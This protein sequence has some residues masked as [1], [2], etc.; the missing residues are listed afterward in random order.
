MTTTPI[1]PAMQNAIDAIDGDVVA[2]GTAVRYYDDAMQLHY[3]AP[4]SDIPR[5]VVLLAQDETTGYSL[6][7]AET[8]HGAGEE[9]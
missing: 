1:T 9:V 8:D 4:M 2:S 5:L 7:C 3:V 6:W